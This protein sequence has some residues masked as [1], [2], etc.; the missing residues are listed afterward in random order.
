MS[1]VPN[2]ETFDSIQGRGILGVVH[3]FSPKGIEDENEIKWWK[4]F[5][6][7]IGYKSDGGGSDGKEH[8]QHWKKGAPENRLQRQAVSLRQVPQ[9]KP[10]T[11]E[12]SRPLVLPELPQR[13][14]PRRV[15]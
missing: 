2:R 5:L 1:D 13:N 6:R 10:E 7:Q 4:D 14:F 8:S 3:G 9:T 11:C 15:E 12:N